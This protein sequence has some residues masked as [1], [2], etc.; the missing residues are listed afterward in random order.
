MTYE[1]YKKNIIDVEIDCLTN[2]IR[3]SIS[4]DIFD[5]EIILITPK[6]IKE[7]KKEDWQFDWSKEI[8]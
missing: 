4:G 1:K 6:L 3:N 8:R 5:T 2:S 7:I